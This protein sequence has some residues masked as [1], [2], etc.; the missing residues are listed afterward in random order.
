MLQLVIW[1]AL[2][3]AGVGASLQHYNPLIDKRVKEQW[4]LPESWQLVAQMPF[5]GIAGPPGEKEYL[6][7]N[8]RIYVFK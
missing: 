4:S 7:V 1:T 5:G 6:P 8:E 2:A 3:E